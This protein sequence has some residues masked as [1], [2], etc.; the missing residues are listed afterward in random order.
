MRAEIKAVRVGYIVLLSLFMLLMVSPFFIPIILAGTISLALYPI[1]V[2]LESRGLSPSRAAALITT[3]FTVV[4]SIPIFFFLVKGTMMIT[5]QLEKISFN[6]KLKDQG[7]QDFVMDLRHDFVISIHKFTAKYDFLDFLTDK[8]I[9]TY[10]GTVNGF[11]MRFFSEFAGSLPTFVMFLLIMILCIF[12]F[13]H[14]GKGLRAFFQEITG[15]SDER[16]DQVT[17]IYIDDARQAYLSNIITGGIQSLIVATG[18]TALG[19]GEFFFVFFI[20]LILS[21]IPVIGAAPV[22]FIFAGIGF[23]KGETSSWIILAVLGCFTGVVDNILRP[24]LATFGESKIPPMIAFVCVIG[25][26]LLLGFPGLFIGL[27]VGSI[28]YDTLP[29]FWEELQSKK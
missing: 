17:A 14:R 19:L 3:I 2:R 25:G 26:A 1:Q 5:Q 13:L 21:F 28:A 27:L 18:V 9:D 12:S 22:A 11:L 16:M 20:T 23:F 8:K 4:I 10:L 24:W 7:V 15:F 6:D 29:I